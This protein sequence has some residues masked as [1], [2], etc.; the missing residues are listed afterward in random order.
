LIQTDH[1][2]VMTEALKSLL[3]RNELVASASA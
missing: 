1:L 3:A 2:S